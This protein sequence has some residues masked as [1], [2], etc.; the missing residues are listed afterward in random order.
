LPYCRE[1]VA[2]DED[3]YNAPLQ[4]L[5][6]RAA[7]PATANGRLA[8]SELARIASALQTTLER[9]AFSILTGRP[10]RSGR[11]PRQVAESV[12]L[13]FVDFS[14]GSAVL[15]MERGTA[16]DTADDLLSDAFSTL[17]QGLTEIRRN[18]QGMPPHFTPSVVNGLVMLCGGISKD[19]V[20]KISFEADGRTWFTLDTNIRLQLK[21]VQKL[22]S[23]REITIVGRLHMGD[24][25]PMSLRCR[26]DT[27]FASI[28]CDLDDDIK[29][30]VFD[31]LDELVMAT[32]VA[33]FQADGTTVRVL[34][35]DELT[36]VESARFQ[37][38]EALAADQDVTPVTD[39]NALRGEPIDDFDEFL[40]SIRSA[41]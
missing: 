11:L 35:L 27:N 38:L 9:I 29:D 20:N 23:E 41:R 1:E 26:I 22:T 7:G 24:F 19:N 32:G 21:N 34:H 39:M 40:R 4:K 8:L 14:A 2:V 12:R 33:E 6:V 30:A 25:D 17:T 3:Q 15:K 16:A 18:P 37:S 5:V 28:P 36:R 10:H 31:L 13:D